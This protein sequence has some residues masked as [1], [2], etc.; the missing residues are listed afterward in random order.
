MSWLAPVALALFHA[1]YRLVLVF[2]S[3]SSHFS[4]EIRPLVADRGRSKLP[5][6]LA[7]CLISNPAANEDSNE[8]YML[9]SVEKVASW[10]QAVGIRRLTVYDREG[11]LTHCSLDL[12]ER[13]LP[14]TQEDDVDDWPVECDIRYPPTPPP[15][16]D[17]DSRPDSPRSRPPIPK[18][19][20]TTIRFP[21]LVPKSK[22]RGSV[23]RSTVKRRRVARSDE[24]SESPM[25]LHIVSYKSGK[26]ALA[27]AAM[28][29][30][31]QYNDRIDN[32]TT[33]DP[34]RPTI[35]EL[36]A[37]LEGEY[38]F[39]SPDLMIVHRRPPTGQLRSPVELE[40]FPP[41]QMR[42]T[43]IYCN[44]YPRT[45]SWWN[46][47]PEVLEPSIDE[48]EFRRALDEFASAEMRLGK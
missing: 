40:G 27:A 16:D 12:R 42:L 22:R 6:H 39:S 34:S 37:I 25:T 47:T 1:L 10:C 17:A 2:K 30:L 8:K 14:P 7:L 38:G 36:N 29:L 4:E 26:P 23:S 32:P 24:E 43:E 5:N 31:Q 46:R 18:L 13:L 44:P 35:Q 20:V 48:A 11:V 33:H 45:R 21:P 19:S 41:W 28:T 15:S 3:L 9:A